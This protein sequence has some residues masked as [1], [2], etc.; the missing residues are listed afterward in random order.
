MLQN[1]WLKTD[2]DKWQD[3]DDSD[4]DESGDR[5]F[6]DVSDDSF[7]LNR[8]KHIVVHICADLMPVFISTGQYFIDLEVTS[9]IMRFE[10]S[11]SQCLFIE[12]QDF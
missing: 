7:V 12:T 9:D 5:K 10:C 8:E 3:E 1:H 11:C 4:V 2:F 6:E